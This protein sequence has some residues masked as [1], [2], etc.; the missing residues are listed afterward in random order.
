MGF[1][2]MWKIAQKRIKVFLLYDMSIFACS[3]L[4]RS[5]ICLTKLNHH[6]RKKAGLFCLGRHLI[7]LFDLCVW[8]YQ[9]SFPGSQPVRS[10]F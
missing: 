2:D 5:V 10:E 3:F 7:R 9:F 4:F 8:I 6:E 1:R